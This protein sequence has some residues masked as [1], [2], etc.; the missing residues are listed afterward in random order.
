MLGYSRPDIKIES[1]VV[2]AVYPSRYAVDVVT[3]PTNRQLKNIPFTTPV[4]SGAHGINFMPSRG[5]ACWVML[6]SSDPSNHATRIEPC[7][8]AWQAP[9]EGNS[10][11]G[12][13]KLLNE[14]DLSLSTPGGAEVLL[15]ANGLVEIKGGA[16]TRTLYIP[17]TNTIRSICQNLEITTLGGEFS[18][19][20]LGA[21]E[22]AGA[23]SL[24]FS[25]KQASAD[26]SAF[27]TIT[28]GES[29]GGMSVTLLKDGDE[30]SADIGDD[31]N[32]VGFACSWSINKDGSVKI[33]AANTIELSAIE[34]ITVDSAQINITATSMLDLVC[35]QSS[36]KITPDSIVLSAPSL[37]LLVSTA[38]ATTPDGLQM[39]SLSANSPALLTA[40]ALPFIL[41]HTHTAA[42]APTSPPIE[43][44][45]VVE[46]SV[47]TL[48]TG[49]V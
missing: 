45:T 26:A 34:Q 44:P 18:W 12:G 9:R 7:I 4:S 10:F 35:G 2:T 32:P 11:S 16:L 42:G 17:T 48:S 49:I 1:A 36:I 8:L 31:G 41:T 40:A 13:R 15:R 30:G 27:L 24:A 43:A 46:S 6:T 19:G 28:A 20:T 5:S 38:N 21:E 37:S 29:T 14:N 47:T 3:V 39:L 23:S 33:S 22:S 25:L